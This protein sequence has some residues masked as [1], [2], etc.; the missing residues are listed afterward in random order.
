MMDQELLGRF[1][2]AEAAAEDGAAA[3]PA[4]NEGTPATGGGE[5]DA[6]TASPEGGSSNFSNIK[7]KLVEQ[8]EK[9]PSECSTSLG[10]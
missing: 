7:N 6:G 10:L 3:A 2:R 8:L 5:R 4:A 9:L 1:R